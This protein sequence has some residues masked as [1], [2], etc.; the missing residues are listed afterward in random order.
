MGPLNEENNL[1]V[2]EKN[3]INWKNGKILKKFK[4][5]EYHKL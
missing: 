1:Q 5:V 3:N 2:H 4:N